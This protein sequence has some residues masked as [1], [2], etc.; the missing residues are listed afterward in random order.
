MRKYVATDAD[1]ALLRKHICPHDT[2]SHEWNAWFTE[3]KARCTSLAH[4]MFESFSVQ[5]NELK[6]P[7]V[8]SRNAYVGA[9]AERCACIINALEK[10]AVG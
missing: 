7:V 1:I 8:K 6:L 5:E 10:A 4:R 9:A 3:T 2:S